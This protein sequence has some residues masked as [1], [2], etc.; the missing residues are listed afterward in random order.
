MFNF[1]I[2]AESRPDILIVLQLKVTRTP[3]IVD[4]YDNPLSDNGEI[5]I[6]YEVGY[7][8]NVPFAMNHSDSNYIPSDELYNIYANNP[9]NTL[10]LIDIFPVTNS[11]KLIVEG[12]LME[13]YKSIGLI[14]F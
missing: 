8:D 2:K 11:N 4:I 12:L 6:S 3:L 13:Y 1:N 14:G 5:K 10:P 9:P 7:G